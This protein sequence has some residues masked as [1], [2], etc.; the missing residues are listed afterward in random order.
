[1]T[2]VAIIG[3]G[4]CG[5]SLLR[6]FQQAEEKG[7]KIP[8]IVC[9][10]KQENWGG[11]W[12]Y[13]WRTGSDQYG[14][15]IP[16]SMYRY[17]WSNGP[18]ECLEFADYSFDEHFNQP[19]PSFPPREVLYDYILGRAKKANIKKYIQ[20]STTVTEAKFNG[21]QFE[22]S[23][24]NKKDNTITSDNYDYLI[25]A[26]GHFSVPYIPEYE[27][28]KSFP[29]RILH[30][31]DFRDA[32]EFRN[33]DVVVLGS[34]YSAEDI[35]LQ[36]Y[37]YGAKSVTIGYRHNPMGFKWPEGMKEVH[38]LDRLEGNKAIFKDGHEQNADAIILCSGYL[39]HFPFLD[40]S[41]RLKTVNRLYPPKLYKG[42]VWQNNHKLM[43][44]G[45]QDQFHTFNMFDCQAWFAR[46]VIMGK[47]K[48][49]T[50]E[51]VDNDINKWVSE[52]EALEDP[53]QMID[54]QTEYTKDLHSSSDYPAIDFELI[55]K[56]FKVW[57]HHKEEDIM[58]YRN[59]S[60][61]SAVTGTVAPIHHTSWE[62]A[63]DDSM[64]TF[65]KSK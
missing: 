27:G 40:K 19:I 14:D 65:M 49:P 34:S 38:Y 47:I 46:D 30:G 45:M 28:M 21:N 54:F 48:M 44:L 1:M 43:Y 60:F 50:D 57:E 31:H 41:L 9:Y 5:L 51:D 53:I 12:N 33:K 39:H 13:S 11:L 20:F 59:N 62:E 52:E 16:N 4:P 22:V 26:S 17:L 58:T 29:G 61:S 23:V 15:P 42:V 37:K 24:L 63:M 55:R 64:E 56:H 10:E 2:K 32:E 18:K 36:C 35:A 3:S 6:A 7:Q 8:E 25:V